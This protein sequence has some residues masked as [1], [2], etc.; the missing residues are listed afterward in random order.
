LSL[1]DEWGGDLCPL[2]CMPYSPSNHFP[3]ETESHCYA[4]GLLR[5]NSERVA[6]SRV[7][8]DPIVYTSA[9]DHNGEWV[10]VKTRGFLH[11][12]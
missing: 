3:E 12:W 5:F 9:R 1:S 6:T 8:I 4:M 11:D 2:C 7:L 10:T